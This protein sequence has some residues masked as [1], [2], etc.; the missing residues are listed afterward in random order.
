MATVEYKIGKL[1][2]RINSN[3]D[4]SVMPLYKPFIIDSAINSPDLTIDIKQIDVQNIKK[5]YDTISSD[6]GSSFTYT[7]I[8]KGERYYMVFSKRLQKLVEADISD[9]WILECNADYSECILQIPSSTDASDI[10][11]E[12]SMRPWLQRLFIARSSK[13]NY[14]LLHGALV[15]FEGKGI[16]F[17]GDSGAGKSTMCDIIK[18]TKATIIADDRFI[19]DFS[20]ELV[21]FG[22]PWNI[23][24]PQY[25]I[26]MCSNLTKVFLISHGNNNIKDVK[27]SYHDMVYGLF[28]A[29]LSPMF[30]SSIEVTKMKIKYLNF[31]RNNCDIYSFAFRPDV[32]AI[33]YV[34]DTERMCFI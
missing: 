25:S 23:K 18:T 11:H 33:P 8:V 7:W 9:V 10:I 30:M 31:I 20:D 13:C 32:S 17:L 5:V 2:I 24:N 16:V 29:M 21:C 6:L 26:N 3:L 4:L 28:P 19:L 15:D 12:M 14:A 1:Y 22:T 34:I 27:N